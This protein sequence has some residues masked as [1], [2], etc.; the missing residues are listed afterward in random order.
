MRSVLIKLHLVLALVSSVVVCLLGVTGAIMAFEPEIQH[1]QRRALVDVVP[2]GEPHSLLD[3]SDALMRAYPAERITAFALA[4]TPTRA[5]GAILARGTVYI[6]PYTLQITGLVPSG[7]DWLTNVHQWHLR[8]LVSWGKPIVKCAGVIMVFLLLSGLYLW[9][10]AKRLGIT[11]GHSSFRTWF[12]W[13]NVIG[14]YTFV[15]LLVLSLTGVFIGF[16]SVSVPLAYRLT[17]STPIASVPI[18]QPA[19]PGAHQ[20]P[21]DRMV[22]IA[23]AA[24]PGAAAFMIQ[25]PTPSEAFLV[26]MRFPEDR[27][28]GG[29]SRVTINSYSGEV[30]QVDNSRTAP[31][32]RRIEILNRA[33][34]TGDIFGLPSKV[35]M[36]IASAMAPMQLLT[37]VMMWRR[38]KKSPKA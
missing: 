27:T 32:G 4:E 24:L 33:I 25:M 1:W 23:K 3:V 7:P 26:R 11:T 28:P 9:W 2:A 15:F 38:R 36:A 5:V 10:P 21:A 22:E 12:D 34:H 13:H 6:N 8:L 18:R 17:G 30:L 20:L 35:V 37:G 16:D 31:A 14:I 19:I 29:R